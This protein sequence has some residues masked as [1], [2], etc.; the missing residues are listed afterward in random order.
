M[1]PEEV[2]N[3]VRHPKSFLDWLT[4]LRIFLKVK[5]HVLNNTSEKLFSMS[6]SN[7]VISYKVEN[8]DLW[9]VKYHSSFPSSHHGGGTPI[10]KGYLL[11]YFIWLEGEITLK[12]Y[13]HK[14]N[15]TNVFISISARYRWL[16]II[17]KDNPQ[18]TLRSLLLLNQISVNIR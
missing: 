18:Y 16:F 10:S 12:K 9:I 5:W 14:N 3:I 7:H 4:M 13:T 15:L 17:E 2:R 1:K 11:K 8:L 6:F